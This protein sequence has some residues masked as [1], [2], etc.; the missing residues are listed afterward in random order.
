MG[1]VIFPAIIPILIYMKILNHI[2]IIGIYRAYM[3]MPYMVQK[4]YTTY[5]LAMFLVLLI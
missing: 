5:N 1:N 2:S 3:C 4:I